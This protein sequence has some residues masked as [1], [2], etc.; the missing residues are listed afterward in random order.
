MTLNI[1]CICCIF[2]FI[3]C[4]YLCNLTYM[5]CQRTELFIICQSKSSTYYCNVYMVL[6]LLLLF[7]EGRYKAYTGYIYE[8]WI[9]LF[10]LVRIYWKSTS[11]DLNLVYSSTCK[12]WIQKKDQH[13]IC[14]TSTL[15]TF[16][17]IWSIIWSKL[18][19]V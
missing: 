3:A 18:S 19:W 16:T 5:N 15:I 7:G 13:E 12:I 4:R 8:F 9:Y 10:K 6:L 14:R 11:D 2:L 1:H 17:L